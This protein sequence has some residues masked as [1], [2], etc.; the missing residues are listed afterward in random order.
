MYS[1]SDYSISRTLVKE[2]VAFFNSA[3]INSPISGP[4]DSTPIVN[5]QNSSN[6][7]ISVISLGIIYILAR[8]LV[9]PMWLID[10][11]KRL[12]PEIIVT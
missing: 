12:Q 7:I 9:L 10:I 11:S 3:R 5:Q 2:Q 6:S 1:P 8:P 4:S